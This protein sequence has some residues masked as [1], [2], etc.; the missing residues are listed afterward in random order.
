M[1]KVQ[2]SKEFEIEFAKKVEEDGTKTD[3]KWNFILTFKKP[4]DELQGGVEGMQKFFM[5]E[6]GGIDAIK[7]AGRY[8]VEVII[9]RTFDPDE[10][11][12]ALEASIPTLQSSLAA[13]N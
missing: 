2:P 13:I 11:I 4:L 6:L 8:G 9:A 5:E 7:M 1:P 3:I 10:V 12:A